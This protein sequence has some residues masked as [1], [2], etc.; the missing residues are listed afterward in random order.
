MSCGEIHQYDTTNF[1]IN[2]ERRGHTIDL[3]SAT[4]ITLIFIKPNK[5]RLTVT[6][7]FTTDGSDGQLYYSFASNELDIVGIWEYQVKYIKAGKEQWS[8]V[9]NFRVYE[10]I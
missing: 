5:D 8:N 4:S 10:N 6:P 7:S 1:K 2:L 9:R 3:S